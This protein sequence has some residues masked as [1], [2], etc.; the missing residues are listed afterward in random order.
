M[1]HGDDPAVGRVL[2]RAGEVAARLGHPR[3]GSG[4]LMVSMAYPD[5]V[6]AEVLE[7]HGITAPALVNVVR[8]AGPDGVGVKADQVVLAELGVSIASATIA[9]AAERPV[10]RE[11]LFPLGA[12]QAR[13]RALAAMTTPL[14]ADVWAGYEASL[15]LALARRERSHYPGH[16]LL[17][18]M[19]LDPGV[20]WMLDELDVDRRA[21]LNDLAATLPTPRRRPRMGHRR[22]RREIVRRYQ[23]RTGRPVVDGPALTSLIDGAH[24]GLHA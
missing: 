23:H 1:F 14:G 8:A 5:S 17:T 7:R 21:L 18:L 2:R 10:G 6:T 13:D 16:L 12:R 20:A 11:P 22:R 3:V 4:H 19:C 9:A 24:Q 15:R